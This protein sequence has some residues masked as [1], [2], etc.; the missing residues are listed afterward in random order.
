MEYID[1]PEVPPKSYFWGLAINLCMGCWNAGF[2][3]GGN[4]GIA[5][6]FAAQYP[7]T[8]EDEVADKNTWMSAFGVLGLMLGSIFSKPVL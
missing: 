7:W 1:H 6:I 2:V 3:L 4:S 5:D 8:T